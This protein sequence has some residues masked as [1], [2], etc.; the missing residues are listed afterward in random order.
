MQ[1]LRL[2]VT[3]GSRTAH[4]GLCALPINVTPRE[5]ML[6]HHLLI[7]AQ[8]IIYSYQYQYQVNS[9][10]SQFEIDHVPAKE[11]HHRQAIL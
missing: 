9:T 7:I 8:L 6:A 11:V 10:Y 3:P 2:E 5:H 4:A 1:M